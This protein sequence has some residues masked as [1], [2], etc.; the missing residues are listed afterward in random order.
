MKNKQTILETAEKSTG[1][2]QKNACQ[3]I[4]PELEEVLVAGLKSKVAR[5]VPVSGGLLKQKAEVMAFQL[6]IEG[7]NVSNRWLR[8]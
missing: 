2:H 8:A 5:K 3:G 7:Y 1:C 4:Y 6:N